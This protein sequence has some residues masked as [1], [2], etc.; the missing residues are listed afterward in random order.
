MQVVVVV[1][2]WLFLSDPTL[3]PLEAE[4]SVGSSALSLSHS[5]THSLL[6]YLMSA[7][8]GCLRSMKVRNK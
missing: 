7:L 2:G 6:L 3:M 5:L 1:V 8:S 4:N